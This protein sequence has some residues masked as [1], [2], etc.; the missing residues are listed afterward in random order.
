MTIAE[1]N[2]LSTNLRGKYFHGGYRVYKLF[3]RSWLS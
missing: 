1:F 2:A 3:L